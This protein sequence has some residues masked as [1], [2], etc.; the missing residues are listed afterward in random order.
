MYQLLLNK[1]YTTLIDRQRY[2][3]VYRVKKNW[4]FIILWQ[5]FQ[6]CFNDLFGFSSDKY[7]RDYSYADLFSVTILFIFF[8]SLDFYI[9]VKVYDHNIIESL[10]DL[11]FSSPAT[12]LAWHGQPTNTL[13]NYLIICHLIPF[14]ISKLKTYI[15]TYVTCCITW[16]CICP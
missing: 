10:S 6:V 7:L 5:S 2:E 1:S 12:F 9:F 11:S 13:L 16:L 8:V 4:S 14:K 15:I 3:H